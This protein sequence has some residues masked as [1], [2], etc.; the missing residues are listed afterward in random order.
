MSK[1]D[2]E[3]HIDYDKME[4]N[5]AV[6]HQRLSR[7]LTMSEKVLYGHLDDPASQVG[8]VLRAVGRSA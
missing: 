1:F 7:P 8:G 3:V 4:Q 6:V 2:P 5:L